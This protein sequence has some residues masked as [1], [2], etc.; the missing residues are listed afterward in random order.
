MSIGYPEGADGGWSQIYQ[1]PDPATIEGLGNDARWIA[2]DANPSASQRLA[3]ITV[4]ADGRDIVLTLTQRSADDPDDPDL[5]DPDPDDPDQD[6]PS[7]AIAFATS[8]QIAWDSDGVSVNVTS[9]TDW[10][11]SF[12]YPTGT[13]PWCS[14]TTTNGSGDQ[15]VW[16]GVPQNTLVSSRSATVT[17]TAGQLVRS[18]SLTQG[19]KTPPNPPGFYAGRIE[20]PLIVD[21][22]WFLEYTLG[23]F[24]MEYDCSKKHSKWVAWQLHAG[25]FGSSGRTNAWRQ[26]SRIPVQY[27]A[28]DADFPSGYDKGHMCSS[29]ERTASREMNQQTFFYSNMSPQNSGLNQGVWLQL[30]NYER[31]WAQVSGDTLYICCGGAITNGLHILKYSNGLAIPKY[32]FKVILRKKKNG[33]YN[34]IGFWYENKDYG[35]R[36]KAYFNSIKSTLMKSV[37]EI[38]EL[39]GLDFFHGLPADIQNRVEQE[40]NASDWSW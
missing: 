25:S 24:A 13:T 4:L 15:S 5:D 19:G 18:L 7:L 6:D 10:A 1:S 34:A 26:D 33:T 37:D 8:G 12:T 17:V 31:E 16:V 20:L 39:T 21:Q 2:V 28:T 3:Y 11:V 29:G 22:Q 38:E 27:Q 40:K 14:T 32:N 30:E 9:N 36:T 35:T 23:Q